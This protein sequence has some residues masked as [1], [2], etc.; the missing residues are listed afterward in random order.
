MDSNWFK[1][2]FVDE[3]KAAL[4]VNGAAVS[5][6]QLASAVTDYLEENPVQS[7]TATVENNVL[8]IK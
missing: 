1:E 6:E 5:D 3:A 8:V 2:L 4:S 7:A